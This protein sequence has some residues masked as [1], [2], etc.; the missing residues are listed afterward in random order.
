MNKVNVPETDDNFYE[1]IEEKT[2]YKK[3]NLQKIGLVYFRDSGLDTL[4][5]ELFYLYILNDGTTLLPCVTING[6]E[7]K[8]IWTAIPTSGS[9]NSH[10]NHALI[11]KV[12]PK[13]EEIKKEKARAKKKEKKGNNET[14]GNVLLSWFK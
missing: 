4:A 1:K 11:S 12:L 14:K 7:H 5:L 6:I 8:H 2:G 3:E 9:T 10:L 13:L